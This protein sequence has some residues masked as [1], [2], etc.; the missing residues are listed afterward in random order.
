MRI[1]IGV[2]EKKNSD[3][4]N[5]QS[6]YDSGN[7]YSYLI[8]SIFDVIRD[9]RIRIDKSQFNKHGNQNNTMIHSFKAEVIFLLNIDI[10]GM[11]S[12]FWQVKWYHLVGERHAVVDQT[13]NCPLLLIPGMTPQ[14]KST[15]INWME[16]LYSC[17]L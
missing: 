1:E 14:Q 3:Q 17:R 4:W 15:L 11:L 8:L 5:L 12:K 9:T 16:K 7:V 6:R 2:F 10:N 13:R